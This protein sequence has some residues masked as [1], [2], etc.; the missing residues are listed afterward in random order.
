MNTVTKQSIYKCFYHWG[1][2]LLSAFVLSAAI[3]PHASAHLMVAQ[4]GTLNFKGDSVFMVLSLPVSAFETIDD[5]G[6]GKMSSAEFSKHRITIAETVKKRVKL[7]DEK[8]ASTLRGLMLSPVK[9]H[10]V[11]KAHSKQLVI[12]GRFVLRDIDSAQ[13]D[14]LKFQIGIFGKAADE[15]LFKVTATR[16]KDTDSA[17]KKYK[18]VL[19]PELFE[20]QLF[21][22]PL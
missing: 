20:N 15:K 1:R 11:G 4:H 14:K 16:K 19:T 13:G 12:M 2:T 17:P 7:S 5:D 9:P 6:D 8:G 10:V 21:S 18:F 3:L 22:G